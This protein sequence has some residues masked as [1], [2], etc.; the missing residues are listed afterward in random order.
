MS[1][2][3]FK[4]ISRTFIET[5]EFSKKWKEIDLDDNDLRIVQETI[6]KDPERGKLIVGTG[7]IRKLR[8]PIKNNRGK[9]SGARV[10]Y[11]D[12]E[13]TK[14]TIL[15]TVFS[16]HEKENLSNEEKKI[17]KSFVKQLNLKYGG[18]KNE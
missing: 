6:L 18:Y 3:Y 16:K 17:I 7:G 14:T 9:S 15:I 8:I 4:V 11:I 10:C 2:K 12:Y 5:A 13:L 1:Y